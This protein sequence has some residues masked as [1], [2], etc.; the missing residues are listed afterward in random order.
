M[1]QNALP[2]SIARHARPVAGGRITPDRP[3]GD[4]ITY[5]VWA[6]EPADSL[7]VIGWVDVYASDSAAPVRMSPTTVNAIQEAMGIRFSTY[8]K[9][10][11]A[12]IGISDEGVEVTLQQ[13][14]GLGPLAGLLFAAVALAVAVTLVVRSRR[15]AN[16]FR[17]IARHEVASREAERARVAREIHDGPL[18]EVAALARS[19]DAD[20]EPLR[21]V[22]AELR[23][24]A[25]G[26]RPP[27]LEAFGLVPALEDLAERHAL[28]QPP[29]R[30]RVR[31]ELDP[32]ARFAPDAELGVY[33]VAQEALTNAATN[34]RA[35]TAW[36]VLRRA[37]RGVELVV[38]DDGRGVPADIGTDR[39]GTRA[40]VAAGHFGLAGMVERARGLDGDLA[41]SNGPGGVGTEVVLVA[42]VRALSAP[43]P[44]P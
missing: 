28:A 40:L 7:G 38:R 39:A 1:Q 36:V 6:V 41:I 26:L 4:V 2:D 43:A 17:Q 20:G 18:Q 33:R 9:V 30:V 12:G 35:R 37:E 42:P 21:A 29:L 10:A 22:A 25:A 13:Q 32:G 27:A 44:S 16:V 23:A 14:W 19:A 24:L 11:E 8:N 15:Q 34:G 5:E 3:I 31:S